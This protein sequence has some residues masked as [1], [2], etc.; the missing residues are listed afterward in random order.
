M[1]KLVERWQDDET[2]SKSGLALR[3]AICKTHHKLP[4]GCDK[5]ATVEGGPPTPAWRGTGNKSGQPGNDG[6][7]GVFGFPRMKGL[8]QKEFKAAAGL[9]SKGCVIKASVYR[10]MVVALTIAS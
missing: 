2:H 5:A 4:G 8:W 3:K 9:H 1:G 10:V 6:T 7:I